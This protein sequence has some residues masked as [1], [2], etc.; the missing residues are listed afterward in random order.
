MIRKGKLKLLLLCLSLFSIGQAWALVKMPSIFNNDMVLQRDQIV[1]IWGWADKNEAVQ[2]SFNN[3]IRKTKANKDGYWSVQLNPMNYGG[4]YRMEIKGKSNSIEFDNILIGDVW[5]CSGQSNMEWTVSNVNNADEEI[6]AANYPLIRSFNVTKNMSFVPLNNLEGAWEVCSPN[7][8]SNFTA[9]GYFFA[10]KLNQELNI[11]IGIINSSWGGTDIE[12]WISQDS[13]QSLSETFQKRYQGIARI[14]NLNDYAEENN[15]ARTAYSEALNNDPG[16]TEEWFNP[17]TN[18]SS[19]Q[20]ITVP[21]PWSKSDLAPI[22]GIIWYRYSFSL[23][24][25]QTQNATMLSLGT[26]DDRDI[27]W[28]NGTKVGEN[29]IYSTFR[30]YQIPKD[31]LK[32]GLNTITVRVYD[33]GGDGGFM[34]SSASIYLAI[35]DQNFPLAGE[36]LYKPSV[37][38]KMY[39]YVDINPN[40]YPSLLYNAMINPIIKYNIKGAIW[41]QGENN[42]SAAYNY[43]TLFPNMIQNW[44]QKWGTE[45]PFYWVQLTNFMQKDT[46]PGRS[47]WAELR[48]AQSMTLSLPKTGQAVITDIGDALDIHPRNKQDVGLR[49]AQIAL[50]KDY[51]KTDIIYSGPT[52]NSIQFDGNKAIITFD[53]VEGGFDVRSK[54]GYIEGFAIAGTDQKY[55]WAKAYVE[56]G[57][58]IVYSNEVKKPIAVRYSWSDNPDVNLFNTKGLPA[59]PFRTDDWVH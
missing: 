56:D 30:K 16:L 2:V 28:I 36:W 6:K 48:E 44:R 19:W 42:A 37:T 20:K 57:K 27:T 17:S 18:T 59:A 31:I 23:T 38:N 53:N 50:N 21:Q 45:F 1:N 3:Q 22:D 52:Y 51:G 9:V 11:P 54:Y 13:F 55:H 25:E 8:V 26:I 4:P 15:K 7:T 5:I 32:E 33:T 49:L 40:L 39:N 35:G 58:V 43:R 46:E 24:K 12:T 14:D 34:D 29:D 10:R 47:E 41:Y